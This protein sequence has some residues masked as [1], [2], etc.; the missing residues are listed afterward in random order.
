MFLWKT[1]NTLKILEQHTFRKVS[2]NEQYRMERKAIYY[3][4]LKVIKY[5]NSDIL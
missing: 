2:R 5:D 1:K 4:I 3:N